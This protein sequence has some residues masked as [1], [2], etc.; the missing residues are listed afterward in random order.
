LKDD[1]T[2]AAKPEL[3]AEEAGNAPTLMVPLTSAP[4]AVW[5]SFFRFVHPVSLQGN[6]L[7]VHLPSAQTD[8]IQALDQLDESIKNAN[9]GVRQLLEREAAEK[10]RREQIASELER[11][12]GTKT[13]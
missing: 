7:F 9:L 2:I 6:R 3:S 5:Q 11:W 10:A 12:W 1:I 13:G 8:V 4:D